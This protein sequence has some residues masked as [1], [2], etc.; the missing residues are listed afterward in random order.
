[1]SP[2][3]GHVVLQVELSC[4]TQLLKMSLGLSDV[5]AS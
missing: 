3:K 2:S 4:V 5:S 1:M